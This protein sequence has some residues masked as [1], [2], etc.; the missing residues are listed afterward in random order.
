MGKHITLIIPNLM[1]CIRDRVIPVKL[2][3]ERAMLHL[4]QIGKDETVLQ[5]YLKSVDGSTNRSVGEFAKRVLSKLADDE[6]E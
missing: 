2:A 4:L 3:S 1:Q 6:T 5:N